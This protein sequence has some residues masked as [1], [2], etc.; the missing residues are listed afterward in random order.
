M[1]A[2][3]ERGRTL[4]DA[5]TFCRVSLKRFKSIRETMKEKGLLEEFLKKHKYDPVQKYNFSDFSVD[6]EPMAYMD[7]SPGAALSLLQRLE[8]GQGQ[9]AAGLL[10]A[11]PTLLPSPRPAWTP[12]PGRAWEVTH[13][14][15]CS[16][17]GRHG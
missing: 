6:Y 17:L 10:S 5:Q 1:E 16:H 11:A 7:V 4:P 2:L 12:F 13:R 8:A 3:Q 14:G 15:L 9:R